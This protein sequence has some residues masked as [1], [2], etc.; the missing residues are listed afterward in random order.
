MRQL[1]QELWLWTNLE[2]SCFSVL[3]RQ[4]EEL[5]GKPCDQIRVALL[6]PV[7]KMACNLVFAWHS[8]QRRECS[9]SPPEVA[10]RYALVD[11][12]FAPRAPH[13]PDVAALALLLVVVPPD[14]DVRLAQ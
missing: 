10:Q 5:R 11:F 4:L 6:Y 13:R 9:T 3:F 14:A 1:F 2:S 8:E 12:F 7:P